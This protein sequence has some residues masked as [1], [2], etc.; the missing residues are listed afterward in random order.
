MPRASNQTANLFARIRPLFQLRRC[1]EQ[2]PEYPD[3]AHKLH[4]PPNEE[5][6]QRDAQDQKQRNKD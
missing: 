6:Q 3:H 4:Q 2:R 5:K 1:D